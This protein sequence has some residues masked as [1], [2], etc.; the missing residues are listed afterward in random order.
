MKTFRLNII[1]KSYDIDIERQ[2][3]RKFNVIVNG[4]GYEATI[5]DDLGKTLLMAVD[6]GLYNIELDEEPSSGKIQIKV[7]NRERIVESKDF[8]SAGGITTFKRPISIESKGEPFV[9]SVQGT[10]A[11]TTMVN[12]ILAPMPGKVISVKKKVG[13]EVKAKDVV[14]I[15]EAMKMENEITS[16]RDGK[17]TD[18]RVKEGDNVD[19]D[20]V[21]VVIG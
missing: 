15:L 10:T 17:V 2:E 21:L 7:N 11:S 20:D 5:E 16:N 18:V 19:A 1:G 4:K 14:I 3:K 12:G 6:G 13:D 9:E 8:L